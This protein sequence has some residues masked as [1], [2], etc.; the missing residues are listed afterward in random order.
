MTQGRE[1]LWEKQTALVS[2]FVFSSSNRSP[3]SIVPCSTITDRL[4][5]KPHQRPDM[6]ARVLARFCVDS[7]HAASDDAISVNELAKMKGTY[8]LCLH[9]VGTYGFTYW[10]YKLFQ[11][12][13]SGDKFQTFRPLSHMSAPFVYVHLRDGRPLD[14]AKEACQFCQPKMALTQRIVK[15]KWL[16]F[17][18]IV[19]VLPC[20]LSRLSHFLEPVP[21]S[22]CTH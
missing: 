6:T 22:G 16:F 2:I 13:H 12:L 4:R 1:L 19:V 9:R 8:R 11:F 14:L 21:L 3:W 20:T 18:F 10:V 7:W 15:E 5:S 17:L